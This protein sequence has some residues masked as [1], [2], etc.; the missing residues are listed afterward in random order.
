V[1]RWNKDINRIV[2]LPDV[3]ERM[4]GEGVS[5]SADRRNAFY[6]VLKR[7]MAKWQNVVKIANIKPGS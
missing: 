7:D 6:E 2:Q 5:P 1:A 3:K 4:A